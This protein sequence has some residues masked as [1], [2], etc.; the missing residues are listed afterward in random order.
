MHNHHRQKGTPLP[1]TQTGVTRGCR[2]RC[3][4]LPTKTGASQLLRRMHWHSK[5]DARVHLLLQ[6]YRSRC[7]PHEAWVCGCDG[8]AAEEPRSKH[9]PHHWQGLIQAMQQMLVKL[10]KPHHRRYIPIFV[11]VTLLASRARCFHCRCR[12]QTLLGLKPQTLFAMAFAVH[13]NEVV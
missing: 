11:F 4:W 13:T 1:G 8:A 10:M 12:A 2:R 5:E 7:V 3:R 9:Q 6:H